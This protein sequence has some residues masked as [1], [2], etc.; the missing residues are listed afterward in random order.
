MKKTCRQ[1]QA[2]FEITQEDLAFYDKISP[3]FKGQKQP[4]PPPTLCPDCRQQ[5]RLAFRNERKLYKRTCDFSN[6]AIISI[7]SPDSPHVIYDQ[8]IWW[9]DKWDPMSYGQKFDFNRPFYEQFHELMLKVPRMAC[10]AMNNE[11]ADFTTF[12]SFCKNCYLIHT[13]DENENCYYA[14]YAVN[15]KDCSDL[16]FTYDSELCYE[17]S[18]AQKC[19]NVMF[20]SNIQNC[21]DSLFIQDCIGCSNCI[22]CTGLRNKSYYYKN[23]PISVEEFKKLKTD[24]LKRIMGKVPELKK[25]F[26]EFSLAFPRKYMHSIKSENCSGDYIFDSHDLDHCFDANESE[27]CK[28]SSWLYQ[29]KDSYDWSFYGVMGELGY[30]LISVAQNVYHCLF[31]SNCWGSNQ[32]VMLSDLC[33]NCKNCFGCVALKNKEYCVFNV[34][35]TKE[36]YEELV[37]QIIAHMREYHE[38]GEFFPTK[39][40]PFGYNET[41]AQEYFPLTEKEAKEQKHNWLSPREMNVHHGK[42]PTIP[43]NIHEVSDDICKEILTCATC[44]KSFRII[45]Q[46]LDFYRHMQ[47]PVPLNCFDCRHLARL[48][49][50][51]PRKLWNR[52]CMKCKTSIETTFAPD[53]PEIVYCEK[54]YLET[55]Y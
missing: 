40:S 38:W 49:A 30:E 53:R 23:E 29:C 33:Q 18:D 46:E 41:V 42:K 48:A 50:R 3:V 11:N 39:N 20:G 8:D 7:Y 24:T 1:C 22:M 45:I 16:L 17:I 5:R 15:N 6:K 52:S 4:I 13:A 10:N 19:Y 2:Q 14:V 54:C 28:Y 31:A 32:D 25:E 34:Q 47:L 27:N 36:E 44:N 26:Y 37:T 21:H 9:S 51:N 35:Y 43:T 55:V 12:T